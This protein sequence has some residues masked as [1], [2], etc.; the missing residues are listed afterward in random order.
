ML[1]EISY[2]QIMLLVLQESHYY[3]YFLYLLCNVV[4]AYHF[5]LI[6]K[7]FY[8]GLCFFLLAFVP[9]GLPIP[10]PL[11][12]RFLIYPTVNVAV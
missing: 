10:S 1:L 11:G 4:I 2:A 5:S 12:S 9:T 7:Y 6:L 8:L 3:M